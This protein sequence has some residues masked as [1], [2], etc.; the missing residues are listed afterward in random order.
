MKRHPSEN[1]AEAT[2]EIG[3]TVGEDT[4]ASVRGSYGV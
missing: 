1:P 2:V 4:D 3:Q